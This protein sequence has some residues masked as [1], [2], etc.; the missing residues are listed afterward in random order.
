[1]SRLP[2]IAHFGPAQY[3]P[4]LLDCLEKVCALSRFTY[5]G[6]RQE[7][8]VHVFARKVIAQRFAQDRLD[9]IA[10]TGAWVYVAGKTCPSVTF[11]M[12]LTS[13]VIIVLETITV[14][15]CVICT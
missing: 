6:S 8:H 2:S 9:I 3:A 5:F 4:A 1:V 12:L 10:L 15:P 11:G 7:P 13:R 14:A